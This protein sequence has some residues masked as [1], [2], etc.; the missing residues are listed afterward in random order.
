MSFLKITK[1][2]KY[3][4]FEIILEVRYLC[5]RIITDIKDFYWQFKK[6]RMTGFFDGTYRPWNFCP[7]NKARNIVIY[8]L[9]DREFKI[10]VRLF[11]KKMKETKFS[12]YVIN[13]NYFSVKNRIE[14]SNL[15]TLY[16]ERENV[17][18]D[19]GAYKDGFLGLLRMNI[20]SDARSLFFIN[21]SMQLIPGQY[22]DNFIDKM[23]NF[24]TSNY[25]F[26]APYVNMQESP[27]IQ[28]C[29]LGFSREVFFSKNFIK[30]WKS[31]HYSS[32]KKRN[33]INGEVRLSKINF[34]MEYPANFIYSSRAL[35]SILLK[36]QKNNNLFD[37]KMIISEFL[38]QQPFPE[39]DVRGTWSIPFRYPPN[40]ASKSAASQDETQKLHWLMRLVEQTNP[41]H[42]SAFLMVEFL[43]SPF[44]KKDLGISGT[45]Q[46]ARL[47][48][49]Y[50]KHLELSLPGEENLI[51]RNNL[52]FEWENLLMVKG[53]PESLLNSRFICKIKNLSLNGYI[54]H[55]HIEK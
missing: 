55:G 43:Q 29:F 28:S 16:L 11:L 19:F 17:G 42:F 7:I 51:L 38:P 31:H 27:H 4:I 5:Y 35:Y 33:I 25:K 14:I 8:V 21:D 2:L 12:V 34:K 47:V 37:E 44:L 9:Y 48:L 46:L 18:S 1:S 49:F 10:S 40:H 13:N 22:L 15:A 36:H 52:L 39:N 3:S 53:V 45:F 50:K 20:L 24:T 30:F 23:I 26:F 32:I 54:P 41:T 6:P